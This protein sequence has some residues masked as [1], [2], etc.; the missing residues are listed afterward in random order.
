MPTNW[1]KLPC[2]LYIVY[3]RIMLQ[4]LV[5]PRNFFA[6]ESPTGNKENGVFVVSG[7]RLYHNLLGSEKTLCS[8]QMNWLWIPK[9]SNSPYRG[10]SW[11]VQM[12]IPLCCKTGVFTSINLNAHSLRTVM[13]AEQLTCLYANVP[14]RTSSPNHWTGKQ[15]LCPL[16][17]W[18]TTSPC[19]IHG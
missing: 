3:D 13:I 2:I 4:C 7:S 5:E 14:F 17:K 18:R 12:S 11:P 1:K 8:R 9:T 10:S 16:P 19:Y 15:Q 6:R